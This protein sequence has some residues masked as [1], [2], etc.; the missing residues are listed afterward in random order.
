MFP[1]R[2]VRQ[3]LDALAFHPEDEGK[4]PGS[5]VGTRFHAPCPPAP[6]KIDPLPGTVPL[7]R[8]DKQG[9]IV[10]RTISF[11]SPQIKSQGAELVPRT[12]RESR[13]RG[14]KS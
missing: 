14:G 3:P 12:E 11:L 5:I 13:E 9:T 2:V 6:T 4:C 10:P 1:D 7:Y 8:T